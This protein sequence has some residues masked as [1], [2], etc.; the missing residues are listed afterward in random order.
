MTSCRGSRGQTLAGTTLDHAT[1]TLRA[2]GRA[3]V[4][5]QAGE[6]D[7]FRAVSLSGRY[8]Q[9]TVADH[10]LEPNH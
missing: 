1:G 8:S 3:A 10:A 9:A 6:A 5:E 4:A 2:E 7:S